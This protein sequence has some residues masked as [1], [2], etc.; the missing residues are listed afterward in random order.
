MQFDVRYSSAFK[1]SSALN[2][3]LIESVLIEASGPGSI[4]RGNAL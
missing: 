2:L 1:I 3:I 4:W